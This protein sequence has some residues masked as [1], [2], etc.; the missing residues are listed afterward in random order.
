MEDW[1]L[2]A[3]KED[4]IIPGQVSV[5]YKVSSFCLS[6]KIGLVSP[7][8]HVQLNNYFKMTK[9]E[10]YKPRSQWQVKARLIKPT[11]NDPPSLVPIN[12][13][14]NQE[15]STEQGL[16]VGTDGEN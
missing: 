5:T 2:G 6:L 11:A 8:F 12:Q 3:E 16:G 1:H 7:Q 9:W 14:H 13:N 15:E 10:N 4:W